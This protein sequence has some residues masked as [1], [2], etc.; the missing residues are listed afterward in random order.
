[1]HIKTEGERAEVAI[2]Q[3]TKP[4][5]VVKLRLSHQSCTGWGGEG[6]VMSTVNVTNYPRASAGLHYTLFK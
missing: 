2:S 5:N 3:E 6:D 1:M 4:D